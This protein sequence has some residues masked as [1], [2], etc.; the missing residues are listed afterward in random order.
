M[1]QNLVTVFKLV[2]TDWNIT[3]N[4]KNTTSDEFIKIQE[5]TQAA[6]KKDP[7]YDIKRIEILSI[8]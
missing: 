8:K 3:E 2:T 6:F 5:A 4:I 1:P 7:E